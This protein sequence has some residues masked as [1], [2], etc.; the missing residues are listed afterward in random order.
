MTATR[1]PRPVDDITRAV[2]AGQIL[3]G[4]RPTYRHGTRTPADTATDLARQARVSR[5]LAG[6]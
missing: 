3:D 2:R 4:R 1:K 5:I 6:R